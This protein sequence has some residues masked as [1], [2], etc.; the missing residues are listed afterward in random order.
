LVRS[1]S[2]VLGLLAASTV[3]A[4]CFAI[5][6]PLSGF[7]DPVSVLGTFAVALFFSSCAAVAL[8]LPLFLV[9]DRMRLAR[10]WS[11]AACGALAG[12]LAIVAVRVTADLEIS[13]VG[14]FAAL[15]ALA[16][17]VFW[18]VQQQLLRR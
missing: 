5:A 7:R 16:G 11:A 13:T 2:I 18:T 17:L 15:G 12:V 3:S 14:A 9:L 6:F 8:G 4:A 10:W 1:I